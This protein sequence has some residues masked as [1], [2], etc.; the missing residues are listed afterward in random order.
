MLALPAVDPLSRDQVDIFRPTPLLA[1]VQYA[2][3]N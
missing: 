3:L 1:T 2:T